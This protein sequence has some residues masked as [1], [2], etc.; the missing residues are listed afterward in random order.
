ILDFVSNGVCYLPYRGQW[1]GADGALHT[2]CANSIDKSL[3]LAELLKAKGYQT[4][5]V[6]ADMPADAT[7]YIG[8]DPDWNF[9]AVEEVKSFLSHRTDAPG[10]TSGA[11]D[12]A[13]QLQQIKNEINQTTAVIS[14]VLTK[15]HATMRLDET[16]EANSLG[17]V[18]PQP[19]LD[20]VWVEASKTAN[21]KWV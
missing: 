19:D 13:A 14:T 9:P 6:R 3:L 10:T 15:N 21:G 12:P 20:W 17:D 4:R 7:P 2:R 1:A 5:L 18:T 16:P 11:L 8:K